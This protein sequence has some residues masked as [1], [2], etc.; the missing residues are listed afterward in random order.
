MYI[1]NIINCDRRCLFLPHYYYY[2]YYYYYYLLTSATIH[3]SPTLVPINKT[4][5]WLSWIYIYIYVHLLWQHLDALLLYTYNVSVNKI[6][7]PSILN[8]VGLW[9]KVNWSRYR[10]GVAQ[11][12]GR[13]IALLFLD[14]DTRRGWG[15]SSTPRQHCTPGKEPVPIV[16]EVRWAPGPVWTGAGN[17]FPTGIRSRIVQPLVSRCTD[18]ATRPTGLR[19]P[20]KITRDHSIFA[21]VYCAKV[22][23]SDRFV[24]KVHGL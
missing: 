23:H 16:Q 17:L 13:A 2:Y 24:S 7:C 11:R 15:V 4:K 9:V 5:F 10:P 8:T 19:V 20:S 3:F 18:W 6:A 21:V 12:V 22:S 14:R 1:I